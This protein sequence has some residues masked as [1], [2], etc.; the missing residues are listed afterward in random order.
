MRET[1]KSIM[2]RLHDSRFATRFFKGKGIDIGAA[3]DPLSLYVELFPLITEMKIWQKRHGDGQLMEGVADNSY[4]FV[5]SSHCL[6][7][8]HD[9]YEGLK[10]WFRILKPGGYLI[11]TIPDEDLYE[12][13]YFPSI[14]NNE[15]KWTIPLYKSDSWSPKSINATSMVQVL[16]NAADIVKLELQDAT[17][18][19]GLPQLDQ[20]Q[21]PIGE[22]CIEMII[23]KRTAS[24]LE[25]KG[26]LNRAKRV[27]SDIEL[28]IVTGDTVRPDFQG[29]K[30]AAE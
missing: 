19:T 18:R 29:Q 22:C 3:M 4:D 15:H 5:H 28:K 26:R 23:R 13:G 21:T 30:R 17:F 20:T 24:E 8:L 16:G 12:Q 1:S 7:H 14:L 27:Y 6:E 9:P 11:V 25:L 2:R 10:N